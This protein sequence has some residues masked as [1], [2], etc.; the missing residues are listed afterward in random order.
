M[1]KLF[2]NLRFYIILFGVFFSGGIYL[3]VVFLIPPG[4]LQTIRLTQIYA[5]TAVTY[6][7]FTLLADPFC[8]IFHKFPFR[9]QYLF[10]RRALGV[11]VF[12]FSLLHALFAFFGQLGSFAG[13]GFLSNKY[14]LAISLSF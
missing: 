4:T 5:L 13:L 10:S 8:Y 9:A 12:Y 14:L 3:W 6:L 1:Q 2:H 11:S 7:Y